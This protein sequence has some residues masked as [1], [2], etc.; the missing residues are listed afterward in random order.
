MVLDFKKILQCRFNNS[1]I[2]MVVIE[3]STT[4]M[5]TNMVIMNRDDIDDVDII[6]AG[7]KMRAG[8]DKVLNQ[9]YF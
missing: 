1:M 9:N 5:V 6:S 3:M 8:Y 4:V 7:G 2:V